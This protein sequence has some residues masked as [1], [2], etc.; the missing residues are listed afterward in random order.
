[1]DV[2]NAPKEAKSK[3]PSAKSLAAARK[4]EFTKGQ[5]IG[6]KAAKALGPLR[7]S[8]T[9]LERLWT[10]AAPQKEHLPEGVPAV[11]EE[12]LS[13]LQGWTAAARRSLEAAEACKTV[14]EDTELP[15]VPALPF[16]PEDVK[17][18]VKQSAEVQ[19]AVK[20][21]LPKK[22][23]KPKAKAKAEASAKTGAEPVSKRRRVKGPS[24]GA[25]NIA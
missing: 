2:P 23:A 18:T 11:V 21:A 16:S 4:R 8:L 15:V 14:P 6:G 22:E 1:M 13:K 3:E 20:E 10:K 9:S 7:Q 19:K 17:S 24:G 12:T 25:E 5:T